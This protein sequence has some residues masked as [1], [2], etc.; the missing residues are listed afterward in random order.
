[1]NAFRYP[2]NKRL[3][4][5]IAGCLFVASWFF[6]LI[7]AKGE[8][9]QPV[10][11]LWLLLAGTFRGDLRSTDES[12]FTFLVLGFACLAFVAALCLGWL[13]QCLVTIVRHRHWNRTG[14]E[15]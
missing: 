12:G 10:K 1:M 11:A 3:R 7:G 15:K 9:Q 5:W 13:L 4:M 14:G 8:P 6:P 2:T